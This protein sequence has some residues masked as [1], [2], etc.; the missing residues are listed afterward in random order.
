MS[1]NTRFKLKT[2]DSKLNSDYDQSNEM[3]SQFFK[4]DFKFYSIN[5]DQSI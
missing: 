4:Q 2:Y 1:V 5:I 3:L